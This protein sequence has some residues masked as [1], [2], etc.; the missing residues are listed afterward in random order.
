MSSSNSRTRNSLLNIGTGFMS[1]GLIMILGVISRTVFIKT[2]GNEYLSVNGLYSNV[3]NL[4]SL[5]ELGFGSA[6]VY[7]LYKP[8]AE[9]DYGKI[10]SLMVLYRRVYRAI[11]C[12]IFAIGLC[13]IPF[14]DWIIK[15]PPNIENLKLYYFLFLSNS[16][17]SYLFFAYKASLLTADQKTYV[18]NNI[19]NI[20]H[21]VKT[22]VQVLGLFLLQNYLFY[23][24]SNL[25]F[26][27]F[28]NYVISIS[29]NRRYGRMLEKKSNELSSIEKKRIWKDVKGLALIRVGHVILN[30][31]DNI[32]ITRVVGLS[33]VGLLSN[34][35][36]FVDAITAIICQISNSIQAS[37]GNYFV[38]NKASDSYRL[39]KRIEFFHS[40]VYAYCALMICMCSSPFIRSWIGET[41][42]LDKPITIVISIIFFVQGYMNT[43][44]TFRSALGLFT[45]GWLRPI[46]V[47]IL[48]IILSVLLG[49]KYGVFGVL[50]ATF[51][52]RALVNL[53]YDPLIIHKYG[54][55]KS[56]IP[57]YFEYLKRVL[58]I[59]FSY[60]LSAFIGGGLE[61]AALSPIVGVLAN[62]TI[63]TFVF[64]VSFLLYGA[65]TD[66]FHYW[67]MYITRFL[68]S[69][70]K[71]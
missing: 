13:L 38:E 70:A 9:K 61:T 42:V 26:T 8:L 52:S 39:F 6:M 22:I 40:W 47:S 71:R 54:F 16:A 67:K 31:T 1:R 59:V 58:I 60:S 15:D 53:W 45:Q 48:N 3:L 29:V 41:Y 28:E 36:L 27:V 5:A 57:F 33:W 46:I 43:L 35:S 55:N 23:L 65:R 11:G 20:V 49:M 21:I 7:S 44:S 12:T 66:E 50:I 14:L 25:I 68:L 37:L 30:S 69:R 4:L 2:L 18:L 62:A 64:V 17:V 56:V 10:S 63:T 34:Y 32:I 51:L 24:I 19:R